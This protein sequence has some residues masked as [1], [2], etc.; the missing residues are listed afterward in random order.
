MEPSKTDPAGLKNRKEEKQNGRGQ[1]GNL[2]GT[3]RDHAGRHQQRRVYSGEGY[4]CGERKMGFAAA[5]D[6]GKSGQE[7]DRR[8]G[9]I[10]VGDQQGG[11]RG[12]VQPAGR[13]CGLHLRPGLRGQAHRQLQGQ[14]RKYFLRGRALR[15]RGRAG[16]GQGRTDHGADLQHQHGQDH[17]RGHP[18]G[19]RQGG[20]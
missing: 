10:P 6:H 8:S 13:G 5:A 18:D 1:N 16:G 14:L 2:P 9:G 7:A 3:G 4:A 12:A 15:R 20:L 11:H 17:R 19:E